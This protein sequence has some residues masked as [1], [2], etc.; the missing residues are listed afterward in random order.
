MN[1]DQQAA[2]LNE[3]ATEILKAISLSDTLREL[4]IFK[5]ARIL[6]L[7][8]NGEGR[9]SLD[10]DANLAMGV[11][12]NSFSTKETT[13]FNVGDTFR[14]E[15]EHY[16]DNQPIRRYRLE[17]VEASLK[18]P[19]KHPLG[20][21]GYRVKIKIIHAGDSHVRGLPN[22]KLDI[23]AKEELLPTSVGCLHIKSAGDIQAYTLERITGEKLRAY[24]SSLP[25]YC[26][27]MGCHHSKPLTPR[28]KDLYDIALI[29]R[30]R[31][32]NDNDFWMVVAAEFACASA[33]RFVD[34]L[35]IDSFNLDQ[36]NIQQ[37]YEQETIVPQKIP[38]SEIRDV[39]TKLLEKFTTW[40]ITPFETNK[41]IQ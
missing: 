14:K 37:L 3:N 30:F 9:Q 35:G 27:K 39:L 10:L 6:N 31:K 20:W 32:L 11:S 22:F 36:S 4:L 21:D 24:L 12:I 41:P 7:R 33:S 38:Y 40:G 34:C 18:L 26:V 5:G 23:A 15:L 29:S 2:W 16:F 17:S 28:V 8:L 19:E 1:R 25:A 13:P